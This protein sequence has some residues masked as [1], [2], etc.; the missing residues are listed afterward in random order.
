MIVSWRGAELPD[1]SARD[2]QPA[3]VRPVETEDL[4]GGALF[5]PRSV[6]I[7]YR[8]LDNRESAIGAPWFAGKQ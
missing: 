2:G 6:R 4:V 8:L 1:R 5:E 7:P 3:I